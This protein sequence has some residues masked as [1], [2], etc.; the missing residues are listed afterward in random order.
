MK[1]R[2]EVEI[3][4]QY[5]FGSDGEIECDGGDVETTFTDWGL[6][7]DTRERE[8]RVLEAQ[9]SEFGVDDRDVEKRADGEQVGLFED[10]E[11]D[12]VTLG[13]EKASGQSRWG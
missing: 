11:E 13:G 6:K 2:S 12:Q 8:S 5:V 1:E 4:K 10:V 3:V 7:I 9:A